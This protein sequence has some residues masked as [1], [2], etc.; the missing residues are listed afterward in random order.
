MTSLLD[1]V[2]LGDLT[3]PNRIALSPPPH[4]RCG[5]DGVPGAASAADHAQCA[6]AGLVIADAASVSRN[7][8]ADELAPGLYGQAQVQGWR[9]VAAAVHAAGG[10]VFAPLCHSGRV[11]SYALLEGRAPLAPSAVDDD[12]HLLRV[13]ARLANG[14][15]GRIA[16]SPARAMTIAEIHCAV[17]E[18]RAAA[19]NALR[20]GLDGVEIHAGDGYLPQQFLSP[21][22]NRRADLFGGQLVDRVRFL[23]LVLRAV[24]EEV[25]AGRVGVRISPFSTRNNAPDPDAVATYT[26]LARVLGVAGVAYLHA[27]DCDERGGMPEMQRLL[28][29][30]RP[31]FCGVVIAGCGTDRA[32]GAALLASGQADMVALGRHRLDGAAPDEGDRLSHPREP[33]HLALASDRSI[34]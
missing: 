27:T 6:T 2:R 14:C 22:T 29:I 34:I 18:F 26:Y 25:P 1:P 11:S 23:D 32:A 19:R 8:V 30:V 3:L 5:A 17:E 31:H 13:Y 7:A 9:R 15:H 28:A 21:H 24:L 33:A 4:A 12:L 20:A 10:T 16:A